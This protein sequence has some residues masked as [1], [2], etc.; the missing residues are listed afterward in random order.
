M[1]FRVI[2]VSVAIVVAIVL[3]VGGWWWYQRR[4]DK[5]Y[6]DAREYFLEAEKLR[7]AGG[8]SGKKPSDGDLTKAKE[9][10]ENA[11][12]R[13]MLFLENAPKDP[14]IAEAHMLRYKILWPLSGIIQQEEDKAQ[15]EP[16]K[17]RADV[18]KVEA[19][20]SAERAQ[21]L[22]GKNV[23]A[24]A[25]VL[26]NYFRL[27]E[28]RKAYPHAR[29]LV[30]NLGDTT[31]KVELE[32]F[33]DYVVGAYYILALREVETNHPDQALAYLALSLEREK[34]A[35]PGLRAVPRWRAVDVEVRSLMKKVEQAQSAKQPAEIKAAED[36][37]QA[38]LATYVQRAR[39]ELQETVPGAEGKAPLPKLASLSLTNTDGLIDVLKAA[40][41]KAESKAVAVERIELLLAV[42]EKMAAT[43]D[44]KKWVYE[45]AVRGSSMLTVV[46]FTLPLANRL[47]TEELAKVQER[48]LAVNT[49]VLDRGGQID[50][51]AYLEMSRTAQLQAQNDKDRARALDLAKRGIKVA[52]DQHLPA[53]D[54]RLQ[55]L[56]MQA[57]WLLL[58]DRKVKEAEDHL[59][60]LSQ[61]K[62]L[63]TDVA[64]M[65]GIGAVLDGRLEEGIQQLKVARESPRYKDGW[66]VL[67]ALS[68]AYQALGQLEQALPV[69]E[70]LYAIRKREIPKNRDDLFWINMWQPRL[71][72][73][74]LSL[75][76]CRLAMI[77][78]L[79][80]NPKDVKEADELERRTI[81]ELYADLKKGP[82]AE[83]A[84][85]AL[86]NYKMARLRLADAKGLGSLQADFIRKDIEEIM[87]EIP[88]ASHND[89][90]LL[91]TEIQVILNEP[92]TNPTTVAGAVAATLGAP[93]DMAVRMGE[94][95]RLR[96]G[97]AWQW[98][99]AEQ[100]MMHA[101]AEQ[102]DVTT[103]LVWV[104][105][106]L[107]N[108]RAEEALAKLA[109]LEDH[110]RSDNEKRSIQAYRAGLLVRTGETA[111]AQ[112]IV[113]E[114]RKDPEN[115]NGALLQAEILLQGG[116]AK[117]A[118][119][120]LQRALNKQ[121]QSGLALFW[122]G[123]KDLINGDYA[124][125]L[126]SFERAMQFSQFRVRSQNAIL[127]CVLGM[128]SGPP[129]KP[130]KAN[131]EAAFKEAKRL[132]TAHPKDPVILLAYAITARQMDEIYGDGGMEGA[133]AEMIRVLGEDR[134]LAPSGPYFAAQQ[135]VSAGRP[136][137]ARQ[138]LRG[139]MN[140][141][142]SVL[143]A[144]QLAIAHEDWVEVADC[145]KAAEKLQPDAVDLPLWRGA[146]HE[147]RGQYKEA[148]AEYRKF[149]DAHPLWS[150]GYLGLARLYE[151]Q[152]QYSEA[153]LWVEKWRQKAPEDLAGQ[154]S[155]VRILARD[156][157]V[158][159]AVKQADAFLKEALEKARIGRQDWEAKNPITEKDPEKAKE[160]AE[161]RAKD[162][163]SALNAV[164]L[165]VALQ[166][167]S[168]LQQAKRPAEA[169]DWLSKRALPLV[170]KLPDEQ[171]KAQTYALKLLR[172]SLLLEQGRLL[173]EKSPERAKLMDQAIQDYDALYK[174]RPGDLVTGNNLAWLLVKEKNEPARALGLV[175]QVRKGKFSGQPVSPERLELE[176]LDTLGEV[177][178]ANGLSKEM[179]DLFKD[180]TEKRYG[181]E[182]RALM[183]LGRAQAALGL[184]SDADLTFK[185]VINLSDERAK[186][187]PDP[188]R[189]ELL[190]KLAGDAREERKKT[191]PSSPK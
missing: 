50:P 1:N 44:A 140:H 26:S 187:T 68:Q 72:D 177:Y 139:N 112:E 152:K 53:S 28:F 18:L 146:L 56:Q 38:Q 74:S 141:V 69:L 62:D 147:A 83:D 25:A 143:L 75:F 37:L 163:A 12:G 106:L 52:N 76:R 169:D 3:A 120:I 14:R 66:P 99:K 116:D 36:K 168:A 43:P 182:P 42:C 81:K 167:A 159:E 40:I 49:A 84:A 150:G 135:W 190:A 41:V 8:E 67:L 71:D 73:A 9:A 158:A 111:R 138:E 110:A 170:E 54:R 117:A 91:W 93:T 4:P 78:R 64:Y 97:F 47:T 92:E 124:Q 183:Y 172:A 114:L 162:R 184:R 109:E 7:G 154:Q 153:R 157:Q 30:D 145:L 88:A 19:F 29:A 59:A 131:P 127:G 134:T 32:D 55:N 79:A 155:L 60:P 100:R 178:R 122:R 17:R 126:Q 118:E 48:A 35:G 161:R 45:E 85:A 61:Q 22:D 129:G 171:R 57:A 121:D 164:E 148:E 10:Y 23:E 51:T 137:R 191:E 70:Q 166:F 125:A 77:A 95:G 80:A 82:L 133:L 173:K 132:R 181:S 188:D 13:V 189:K 46:N 149:V 94:W 31:Q 107:T 5:L 21:D 11:L 33:N 175:E 102:K 186:A 151:R 165:I 87:K 185:K 156:G 105:W 160:L 86:L 34:P 144:T 20:R 58:Y 63:R 142:P 176:F 24:Q 104:R 103:Q 90:R 179:L 180:A 39:T 96:A 101:A 123:Q 98:Q 113:S 128:A 119:D 136:D 108:G 115:F 15:V 27:N 130:D 2:A 6:Q 16:D 89:P 65:R 174:E